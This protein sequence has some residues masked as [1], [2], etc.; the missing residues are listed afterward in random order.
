MQP[1]K[2][3]RERTIFTCKLG[4]PMSPIYYRFP[5]FTLNNMLAHSKK[6]AKIV[7]FVRRGEYIFHPDF[8]KRI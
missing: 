1:Q 6:G 4:L 8:Y 5:V 2:D 7:A 3:S